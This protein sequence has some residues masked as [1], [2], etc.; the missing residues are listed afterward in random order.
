MCKEISSTY[1]AECGKDFISG[2]KFYY[3][4]YENRYFCDKCKQIM[5]SRVNES[6]LD[7]QP[8]KI[9]E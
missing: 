1:C 4:W 9:K 5:N 8:R 3:T 7:W 2:E 6:Y